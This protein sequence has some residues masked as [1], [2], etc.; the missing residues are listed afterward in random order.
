MMGSSRHE[1][2]PVPNN[3]SV[4]LNEEKINNVELCNDIEK[5][6]REL[7]DC[8]ASNKYLQQQIES[9][10]AENRL[11]EKRF[12]DLEKKIDLVAENRLLEKR[13]VG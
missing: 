8:M 5:L 11:L 1:Q 10:V 7:Q 2:P 13:F 12:V 9:L 3:Q 4:L 6:K